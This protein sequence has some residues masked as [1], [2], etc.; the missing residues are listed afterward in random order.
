M[1]CHTSGLEGG[2]GVVGLM[3]VSRLS[4][5]PR[6]LIRFR[7]KD[8][9]HRLRLSRH[10]RHHHLA[11]QIDLL[12]YVSETGRHFHDSRQ[13][14]YSPGLPPELSPAAGPLLRA[15]LITSLPFLI[16]GPGKERMTKS[17]LQEQEGNFARNQNQEEEG[18]SKTTDKSRKDNIIICQ[19][20]L[21]RLNQGY[22]QVLVL[23]L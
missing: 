3:T 8:Y 18:I 9:R 22:S 15:A 12:R 2:I 16:L 5:W 7:H 11:A 17:G 23:I 19:L 13:W 1:S 10:L 6:L 21:I 14:A 4:R 20:N